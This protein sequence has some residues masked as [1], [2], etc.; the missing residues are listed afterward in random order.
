MAYHDTQ[1]AI[2]TIR[3]DNCEVLISQHPDTCKLM[4]R[5][6]NC[7]QYRLTLNRMLHHAESQRGSNADDRT[8]PQSHT[9]YRFLTTVEKDMRLHRLHHELRYN[10]DL[11]Y[12]YP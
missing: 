4:T 8:H 12:N 2:T 10:E 5:C 3:C 6:S 1:Q 7:T 11:Y 9:N